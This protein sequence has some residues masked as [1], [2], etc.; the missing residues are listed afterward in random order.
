M[1]E[2]INGLWVT[3]AAIAAILLIIFW[4]IRF[5]LIKKIRPMTKEHL[6]KTG[7]IYQI[8]SIFE[9]DGRFGD[10]FLDIR[11]QLWK[12]DLINEIKEKA[13]WFG[14]NLRKNSKSEKYITA[15][16]RIPTNER[17]LK[18]KKAYFDSIDWDKFQE[19]IDSRNLRYTEEE[20]SQWKK[21]CRL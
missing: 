13:K 18:R 6:E 10:G 16:V 21:G 2:E 3:G 1:L 12:E 19:L 11:H 20:K 15:T 9:V 7:E 4:D 5:E 8:L 17:E 14:I